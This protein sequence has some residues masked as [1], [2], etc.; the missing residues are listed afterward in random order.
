LPPTQQTIIT[1]YS[2]QQ[3]QKQGILSISTPATIMLPDFS[4]HSVVAVMLA[5]VPLAM[6]APQ[7]ITKRSTS[8]LSVTAQLRL[9]DT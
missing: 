3:Q 9:A 5:F 6:T 2:Q 8:E 7:P 4:L 1:C